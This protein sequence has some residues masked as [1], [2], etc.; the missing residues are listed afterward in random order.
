MPPPP[1]KLPGETTA[2][3]GPV[4]AETGAQPFMERPARRTS[5]LYGHAP[6]PAKLPGETTAFTPGQSLVLTAPRTVRGAPENGE[7]LPRA[8]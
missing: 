5:A 4:P 8:R 6:P 1:A 3:S 2:F 7:G